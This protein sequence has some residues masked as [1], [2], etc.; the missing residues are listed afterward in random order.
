MF[1][2]LTQIFPQML[3][4]CFCPEKLS[5]TNIYMTPLNSSP[6]LD[7]VAQLVKDLM[8]SLWGRRFDPWPGASVG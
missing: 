2:Y 7:A 8:F 1:K 6:N 3:S 5:S 4:F